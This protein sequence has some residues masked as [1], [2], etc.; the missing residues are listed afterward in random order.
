MKED[1]IVL[2]SHLD[3]LELMLLRHQRKNKRIVNEFFDSSSSF[4]NAFSLIDQNEEEVK[5]LEKVLK[6]EQTAKSEREQYD[7]MLH[8]LAKQ[9]SQS[10]VSL[11]SSQ[12]KEDIDKLNREDQQLTERLLL[13]KK[14]FLLFEFATRDLHRLLSEEPLLPFGEAKQSSSQTTTPSSSSSSSL[15]GGFGVGRGSF[16][17]RASNKN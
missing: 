5:Q 16:V 9:R 17:A 15:V 14:K 7:G 2:S 13:E 8:L 12:L 6:K 3:R 11:E 10:S 4:Q 1:L